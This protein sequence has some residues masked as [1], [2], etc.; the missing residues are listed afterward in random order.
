MFLATS[1]VFLNSVFLSNQSLAASP[2]PSAF[3]T[4]FRELEME[5][6]SAQLFRSDANAVEMEKAKHVKSQRTIWDNLLGMRRVAWCFFVGLFVL[7]SGFLDF[8]WRNREKDLALTWESVCIPCA[9]MQ[10]TSKCIHHFMSFPFVSHSPCVCGSPKQRRL[11]HSF[12]GSD[13]ARQSPAD[14]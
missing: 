8:D 9:P 12:P 11:A 2:I 1:S 3:A 5:E 6:Q 13:A 14:R 7:F 10:H 4:T